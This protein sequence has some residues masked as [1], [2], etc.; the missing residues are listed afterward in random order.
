MLTWRAHGSG[1][2]RAR[3][4]DGALV[5]AGDELVSV[6]GL[7]N[8]AAGPHA[9][10]TP[11]EFQD[12]VKRSTRF[13]ISVPAA[14]VL[15]GV[16][17]IIA[18]DHSP[19]PYP[20]RNIKQRTVMHWDDYRLD[21]KWGGILVYSVQVFLVRSNQGHSQYMVEFR[22]CQMDIFQFKRSYE[23]LRQQLTRY[24]SSHHAL[25]EDPTFLMPHASDMDGARSERSPY[26]L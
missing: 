21:V 24:M 13:M 7:G 9:D 23:N 22:R 14:E 10:V 4:S 8:S 15:I 6:Q 12:L 19:L 17:E 16:Q 3:S 11:R 1:G 5:H 20:Y 2:G 25:L 26:G 18:A